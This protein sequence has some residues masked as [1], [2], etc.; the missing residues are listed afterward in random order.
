MKTVLFVPGLK[1]DMESRDYA[2][3]I[4]AIESKGYKVKF[5]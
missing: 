3:T 4:D 2:L 1:E 5:V